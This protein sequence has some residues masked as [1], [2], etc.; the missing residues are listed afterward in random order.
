MAARSHV[1]DTGRTHTCRRGP[2]W[3]GVALAAP[4]G[5]APVR[6]RESRCRLLHS[7]L[8]GPACWG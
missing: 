4:D 1:T 5:W 8:S 7:R 2:P 3:H 6:S